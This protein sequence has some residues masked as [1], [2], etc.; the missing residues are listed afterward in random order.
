M[1]VHASYRF[2]YS[3]LTSKI[4][5]GADARMAYYWQLY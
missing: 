2:N 5:G 3:G 4:I 1:I